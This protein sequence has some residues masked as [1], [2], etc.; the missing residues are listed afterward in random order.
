ML[1][2]TLFGLYNKKRVLQV[3]LL[4][5]LSPYLLLFL[6]LESTN[7]FAI[8]FIFLSALISAFFSR[9]PLQSSL[10]LLHMI[11]L[12]SLIGVGYTIKS[13]VNKFLFI[14]FFTSSFICFLSL[15]N[16]AFFL[17]SGATPSVAGVVTSF[18]NI[19]FYNQVQLLF[20]PVTIYYLS[21]KELCHLAFLML[22]VNLFLLFYSGAR[23][24]LLSISLSILLFL[25]LQLIPKLLMRKITYAS[26]SAIIFYLLY[27]IT[28]DA[29]DNILRSGSSGRLELWAETLSNMSL[30]SFLLGNDL[31]HIHQR[32][33]LLVTL[34]TAFYKC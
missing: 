26:A 16:F 34:T 22:I 12:L 4:A 17:I 20:I 8:W 5:A 31:V 15:M 3:L 18:D 2:E 1:D 9:F 28:Y 32:Y 14:I 30:G 21:K 25:R 7:K 23:G 27:I 19:R 6:N 29:N 10:N 24:A 11:M 13:N 33:I